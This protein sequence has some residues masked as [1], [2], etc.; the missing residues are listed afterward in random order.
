[1]KRAKTKNKLQLVCVRQFLVSRGLSAVYGDAIFPS[2]P[3]I[4]RV[5][6]P[7]DPYGQTGDGEPDGV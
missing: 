6:A 2:I 5:A 3:E 4:T 7:G 1:M